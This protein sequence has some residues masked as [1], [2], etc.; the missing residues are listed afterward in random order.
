MKALLHVV[1]TL[2]LLS[3]VTLAALVR[4]LSVG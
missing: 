2:V 3:I 1:A 4:Y